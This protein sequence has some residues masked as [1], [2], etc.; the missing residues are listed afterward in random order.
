MRR[1]YLKQRNSGKNMQIDKTLFP[2]SSHKRIDLLLSNQWPEAAPSYLICETDNESDKFDRANGILDWMK[3]PIKNKKFLDFG[4]GEGHLAKV[5]SDSASLS[6]GFDLEKTGNLLWEE[7][8][9]K[10]SFLTID[11]E[12][13]K[14]NA[15][16]DVICLYDVLDHSESP[17]SVL[18]QIKELCNSDTRIL[19]RCHSWMS[20]HGAHLYKEFNKAWIQVFFSEQELSLMGLKAKI[21]QKYYFPLDTQRAW[22]N[23]FNIE[24]SDIEKS[25]VENFFRQPE[26]AQKIVGFKDFPEWQLS[27]SFNDYVLKLQ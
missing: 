27:Q 18:S 6:L 4:C 12:K 16:Y 10:G 17:V 20:R 13:I 2:E 14:S 26:L 8:D 19:V 21:I 23:G 25:L 9:S 15:P 11:F 24:S 7:P 3:V 5:S 22:F 1:L